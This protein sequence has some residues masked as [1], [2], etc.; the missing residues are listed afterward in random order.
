M[1]PDPLVERKLAQMCGRLARVRSRR[2]ESAD[3]FASD[4]DG[5]EIVAFNFLLASQEALDVAARIIASEGWE[6]PATAREH[7]EILA[8]HGA[9]THRLARDL[10]GCAGVRNLIA[11]TYDAMDLARLHAELPAGVAALEGFAAAIAAR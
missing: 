6:V 4:V 8:A 2:P 3:T 1:A 11:H 5:Q 10:A 9:I 7:F